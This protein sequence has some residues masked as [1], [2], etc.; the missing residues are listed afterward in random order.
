MARK[1]TTLDRVLDPQAEANIR[2]NDLR[3]LLN[4]L[5][6]EE[7]TEGSHHVYSRDGI[8]E[9]I[10]LQREGSKAKVYQVRQVRK[11]L[12]KYGLGGGQQ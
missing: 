2:F 11:I 1:R 3:E 8:R 12:L 10:N 4:S 5:G 9:L 7:R 6:F